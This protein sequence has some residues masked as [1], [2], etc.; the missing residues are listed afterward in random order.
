MKYFIGFLLVL[1]VCISGQAAVDPRVFQLFK[2]HQW[3]EAITVSKAYV[4]AHPKDA[5][6]QF[7]LTVALMNNGDLDGARSLLQVIM[8]RYPRV[9]SSHNNLGVIYLAEGKRND[10]RRE[11]E[12]TLRL[13]PRHTNARRN[14]A[15]LRRSE[16]PIT[17]SKSY[18]DKRGIEFLGFPDTLVVPAVPVLTSS[19]VVPSDS[20]TS[21]ARRVPKSTSNNTETIALPRKLASS[22]A[23]TRQ[24]S[25]NDN[26]KNP[27]NDL[28]KRQVFDALQAWAAA[29]AKQDVDAYL[30]M[31]SADFKPGSAKSRSD[32]AKQR[33]GRIMG[34]SNIRIE[35]IDV[36]LEVGSSTAVVA[37]FQQHYRADLLNEV[38]NKMLVFI[39]TSEASEQWRIV[40]ER[41]SY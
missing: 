20:S 22:A 28:V 27:F 34:P 38:S 7:V 35:A 41:T 21:N 9:S 36:V 3:K 8:K 33:R 15:L 30:A 40:D 19:A 12:E 39:R 23:S 29:W 18:V 25:S 1:G 4:E 5:Q 17:V 31:Y 14:M 10:A 11:F 6:A 37:T 24:E 13:D 16:G 2:N 32:W 26:I